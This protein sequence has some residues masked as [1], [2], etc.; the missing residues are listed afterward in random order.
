MRKKADDRADLFG[1]NS[2]DDE[3]R[4]RLRDLVGRIEGLEEQRAE[5]AADIREIYTEAKLHGY[6]TKI[7]RKVIAARKQD[8]AA[9]DEER[10][11]F[12]LYI[13]AVQG[14]LD[15]EGSDLDD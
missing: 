9:R 2:M 4:R 5:I 8:A 11:L 12:D 3:A 6:D 1:H 14:Y 13:D 10:A 15:M 7:L